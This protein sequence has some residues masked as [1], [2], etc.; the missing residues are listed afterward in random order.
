MC[1]VG[2]SPYFSLRLCTALGSVLVSV[3]MTKSVKCDILELIAANL[4]PFRVANSPLI[5]PV[6]WAK[7]FMHFVIL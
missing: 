2:I 4:G 6:F 1:K 3:R 5:P 7:M